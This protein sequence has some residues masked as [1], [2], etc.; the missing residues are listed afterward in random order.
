[1]TVPSLFDN[2]F[3]AF[4]VSA[5]VDS[6]AIVPNVAV[7]VPSGV[8]S[9]VGSVVGSSV[10]QGSGVGSGSCATTWPPRPASANT[11]TASVSAN[12]AMKKGNRKVLL[13]LLLRL[14]GRDPSHPVIGTALL[15]QRCRMPV[16]QWLRS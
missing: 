4:P 15:K 6:V 13:L 8:G 16:R 9:A 7:V 3:M 2:T 1:L 5:V 11:P 14:H 10:M 12:A